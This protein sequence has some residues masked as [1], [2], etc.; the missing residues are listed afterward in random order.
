M[1][2]DEISLILKNV[3]QAAIKAVDDTVEEIYTVSTENFCPV[4]KEDLK[5][6]AKNELVEDTSTSHIRELSYGTDHAIYVHEILTMYHPHGSAKYLE[7][8]V[9]IYTPKLAEN[10]KIAMEKTL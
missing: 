2:I 6:S 9:T 1:I 7:K 5:H 10:V 4:D 3:E 8:P